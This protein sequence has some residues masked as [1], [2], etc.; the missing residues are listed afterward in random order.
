MNI[1]FRVQIY[2]KSII[3]ATFFIQKTLNHTYSSYL[4]FDISN[5]YTNFAVIFYNKEQKQP[6]YY[7]C[8]YRTG[9]RQNV[10]M[11]G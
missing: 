7:A 4:S 11:G 8:N 1:A 10:E 9:L 5:F 2:I 6:K 3:L